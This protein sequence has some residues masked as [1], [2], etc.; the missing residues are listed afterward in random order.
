MTT[1]RVIP[2]DADPGD[3]FPGCDECRRHYRS[4]TTDAI[5]CTQCC[6]GSEWLPMRAPWW[7][8]PVVVVAVVIVYVIAVYTS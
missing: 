8:L 2:D 5:E 4:N 1:L 7:S 3:G 6:N